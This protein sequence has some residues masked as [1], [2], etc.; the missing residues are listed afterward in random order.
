MNR[1]TKKG[2]TEEGKSIVGEDFKKEEAKRLKESGVEFITSG[3]GTS[4]I[5]VKKTKTKK[6]P[7]Y[8]GK[9]HTGRGTGSQ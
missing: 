1:G 6:K 4:K 9:I 8:K 7:Q 5:E 2:K 3:R